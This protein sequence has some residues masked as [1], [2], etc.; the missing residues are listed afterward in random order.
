MIQ[1]RQR[2]QE[3][4]LLREREVLRRKFA[5]HLAPLEVA[6]PP[7]GIYFT[8]SAG[9]QNALMKVMIEEFCPRFVP[10][11]TVLY[12]D[13]ADKVLGSVVND[14]LQY[15]SISL[16]VH[17]KAPGIIAWDSGHGWVFL[18]EAYSTH[19]SIDVTRKRELRELFPSQV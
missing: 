16:P 7:G 17:R 11:S 1:K 8:L 3:Q 14:I 19:G 5:Q 2:R 9:G 6:K 12:I 13:D 10:G 18:M 15:L 4:G